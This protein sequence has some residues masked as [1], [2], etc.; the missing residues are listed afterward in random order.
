[1][2]YIKDQ[3]K[4]LVIEHSY[5]NNIFTDCK[6]TFVNSDAI[7]TIGQYIIDVIERHG[8][9]ESRHNFSYPLKSK[10]DAVVSIN[11]GSYAMATSVA[12]ISNS[13]FDDESI[14]H[15]AIHDN[16]IT[17]EIIDDM[18]VIILCDVLTDGQ[19]CI[20][21]IN[22]L[23]QKNVYVYKVISLIDKGC[24][25]ETNIRKHC[26]FESLLNIKDLDK[27]TQKEID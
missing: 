9:W 5:K 11:E 18:C 25:G 7:Y 22:L 23:K 26:K 6:N 2:I 19:D 15:I 4:D 10:L 27:P 8:F 12:T 14:N 1:M 16:D 13:W 21:A 17:G 24:G 3:V 20:N